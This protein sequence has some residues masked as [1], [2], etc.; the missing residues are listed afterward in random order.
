MIDVAEIET[1]LQ[2]GS[3]GPDGV[4]AGDIVCKESKKRLAEDGLVTPKYGTRFRLTEDGLRVW[5]ELRR[6]ISYT[7]PWVVKL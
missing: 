4:D 1:F 7:D 6:I 5:K 3:A 2:I